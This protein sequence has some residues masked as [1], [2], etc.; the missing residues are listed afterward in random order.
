M[1]HV[2]QAHT[3]P[4]RFARLHVMWL[5]GLHNI[6]GA[7]TNALCMPVNQYSPA[8]RHLLLEVYAGVAALYVHIMAV[9][10]AAARFYMLQGFTC[11]QE[12]SSNQAHYR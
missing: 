10:A 11:E 6:F 7:L 4:P 5:Q 3:H 1:L 8:T 12:E 2:Q 9:N